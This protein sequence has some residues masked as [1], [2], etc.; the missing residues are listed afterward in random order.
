M[1]GPS[2]RIVITS[3]SIHYTKLYELGAWRRDLIA[4]QARVQLHD[5]RFD[6]VV[7]PLVRDEVYVEVDLR[8]E[9]LG[10]RPARAVHEIAVI[11]SYSIH[12][13]K[14]YDIGIRH[15]RHLRVDLA[16]DHR[17]QGARA[18]RGRIQGPARRHPDAAAGVPR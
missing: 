1:P 14:L 5:G 13:T 8:I 9:C 15:R 7:I 17:K 3:Y 6:P 11:T 16:D 12:Y 2:P 4:V 10:I 18:A